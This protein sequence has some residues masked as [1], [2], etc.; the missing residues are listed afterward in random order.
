MEEVTNDQSIE[1]IIQGKV[2]VGEFF[3]LF[4]SGSAQ[5]IL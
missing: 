4:G 3:V 1:Q 5:L 2:M